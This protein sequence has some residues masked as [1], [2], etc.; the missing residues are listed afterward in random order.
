[1]F[2]P[3]F[4]EFS[5]LPGKLPMQNHYI[6]IWWFCQIFIDKFVTISQLFLNVSQR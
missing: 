3:S 5:F 2:Y 1:M 4:S 6:A